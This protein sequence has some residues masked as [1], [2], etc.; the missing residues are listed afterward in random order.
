MRPWLKPHQIARDLGVAALSGD[1]IERQRSE[2]VDDRNGARILALIDRDEVTPAHLARVDSQVREEIEVGEDRHL[3]PGRLAARRAR[4]ATQHPLVR[5]AR[6]HESALRREKRLARLRKHSDLRKPTAS[7]AGSL[8]RIARPELGRD[9]GERLEHWLGAGACEERVRAGG[10][11][12]VEPRLD[13]PLE[14]CLMETKQSGLAQRLGAGGD[15][16]LHDPRQG[17]ANDISREVVAAGPIEPRSLESAL[18]RI[19]DGEIE[20]E[21]LLCEVEAHAELARALAALRVSRRL[22]GKQRHQS[23]S[24]LTRNDLN[25]GVRAPTSPT[26]GVSAFASQY[27]DRAGFCSAEIRTKPEWI[28]IPIW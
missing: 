6:A 1:Q 28:G 17:G 20:R 7:R 2:L 10:L 13:E 12:A 25:S 26:I 14:V 24:M 27:F 19:D 3:R 4:H 8:C 18:L 23:F 16:R 22:F 11:V 9:L 21:R 15:P 5:A